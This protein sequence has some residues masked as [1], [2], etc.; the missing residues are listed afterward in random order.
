MY[1]SLTPIH[2][3]QPIVQETTAFCV[4]ISKILKI[5]EPVHQINIGTSLAFYMISVLPRSKVETG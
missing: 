3:I 1:T 4:S 5:I 2:I